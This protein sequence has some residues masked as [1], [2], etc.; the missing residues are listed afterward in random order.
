MPSGCYTLLGIEGAPGFQLDSGSRTGM[1][2]TV[3]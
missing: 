2:A 3:T 1:D